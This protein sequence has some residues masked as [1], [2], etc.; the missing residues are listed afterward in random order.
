[1]PLVGL[2]ISRV[3]SR[4]LIAAGFLMCGVTTLM[5]S[6]LNLDIAMG[7][8]AWANFFQGMGISFGMVPLLTV[9]MGTLPKERIGNASGIFALVRNLGSSIGISLV[10][11]MVDRGAQAHQ[12]M[13]VKHLTPYYLNYQSNLQTMQN[14]LTPQVGSIHAQAMAAGKLYSNLVQQSNLL[15]YVDD[16]RWLALLCFVVLPIVLLLKHV[17]ADGPIAAH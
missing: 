11:T 10:T 1:M 7:N 17:V 15:A 9:A 12:A 2:L 16:F 3:D 4:I 14:A 13:L 6:N 8:I 5:I